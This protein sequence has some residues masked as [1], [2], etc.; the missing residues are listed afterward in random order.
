MLSQISRGIQKGAL[1]NTKVTED[2]TNPCNPIL[3]RSPLIC[4]VRRSWNY[5]VP[6]QQN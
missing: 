2:A 4:L 3:T 1:R 6:E 5:Q